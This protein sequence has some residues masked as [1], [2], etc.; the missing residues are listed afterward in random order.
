MH[1]GLIVLVVVA[2]F[3]L[4]SRT[5]TQEASETVIPDISVSR[6]GGVSLIEVGGSLEIRDSR[7]VAKRFP[8]LTSTF[9]RWD[10]GTLEREPV[11]PQK[12]H[13]EIR[14]LLEHGFLLT[15][16]P[17][18]NGEIAEVLVHTGPP[19]ELELAYIILTDP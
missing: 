18:L 11:S 7:G 16:D 19:E 9:E 2:L 5:Q 4:P 10:P 15:F 6:S 1:R 13:E 3:V 8:V 12:A 14:D 17:D